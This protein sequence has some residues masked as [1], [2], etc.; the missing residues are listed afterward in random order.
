MRE[1]GQPKPKHPPRFIAWPLHLMLIF[2]RTLKD[3]TPLQRGIIRHLLLIIDLSTAMMEKDLRPTRY[4]LTI[5]YCQDF[6]NEF[7]EQNPISQIGIIGMRDGLA[8]RVS[9]MSGNPSDHVSNLQALRKEDPKG[10]PSLQN[11][12]DMARAALLYVL[13]FSV[14]KKLRHSQVVDA[15]TLPQLTRPKPRTFSWDSRDPPTLRLSPL[16]GSWRHPYHHLFARKLSHHHYG[17]R[18]QRPS[19]HLP[20]SRQTHESTV[21]P[22]KALQCCL[23]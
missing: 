13:L 17:N 19:R 15:S 4:L 23:G 9:D 7:F 8:I 18:S 14:P 1:P 6:V 10:Q 12:L 16:L 20:D 3:T 22:S 5:R 2:L 11:A 21:E